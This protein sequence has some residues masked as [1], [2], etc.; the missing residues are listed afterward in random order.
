[1]L[2]LNLIFLVDIMELSLLIFLNTL[3]NVFFLLLQT[4]LFAIVSDNIAHCFHFLL[5]TAATF[6]DF[7]LTSLVFF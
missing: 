7:I 2:G 3:L 5:D 1:M 6:R 4:H